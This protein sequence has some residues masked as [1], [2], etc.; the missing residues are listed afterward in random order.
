[1]R[2]KICKRLRKLFTDKRRYKHAKKM[3]KM[4]DWKQRSM[5]NGATNG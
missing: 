3:Y 1:M 4:L 5:V 2:Q